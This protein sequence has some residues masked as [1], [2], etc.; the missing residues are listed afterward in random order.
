MREAYYEESAVSAR[1]AREE[2]LYNVFKISAIVAFVI[3]AFLGSFAFAYLPYLWEQTMNA[4]GGRNTLAFVFGL[5]A[6]FG[7]IVL[8]FG[9]GLLF[10]FMKNRFNVSY[11]YI[12]VEDELRVSKVFNGKKR[13]FL[14]T[15]KTDQMLKLGKCDSDGFERSC[16]GLDKK[17]IRHLTPNP[18]PCEGKD[19]YYFVYSS[20]IEKSVYILE[21]RKELMDYIVLAAGRNK[22]EAR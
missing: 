1:S 20:S 15:F 3:A 7:P 19:F 10:W 9:A 11:D 2:K 6:Y 18:E 5:V 14:K 13:K 21:G 8:V 16:A 4:E 17:R 22:W 12:F